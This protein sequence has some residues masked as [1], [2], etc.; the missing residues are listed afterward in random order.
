MTYAGETIDVSAPV[1]TIAPE[2]PYGTA[3]H[4]LVVSP[5]LSVLP[6]ARAVVVTPGTDSVTIVVDVVSNAPDPVAAVVE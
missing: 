4:P 6:A 3:R 5:A 2:A 1:R